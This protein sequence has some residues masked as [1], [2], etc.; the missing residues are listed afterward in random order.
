MRIDWYEQDKCRIQITNAIIQLRELLQLLKLRWEL[1]ILL[2]NG[3]CDASTD[4]CETPEARRS[5]GQQRIHRC[6][7]WTN[8]R[9]W[10][11]LGTRCRIE[12][13]I[14]VMDI[15]GYLDAEESL[16]SQTEV[17]SSERSSAIV[18]RKVMPRS[19]FSSNS[20]LRR[21]WSRKSC[22]WNVIFRSSSYEK[23]KKKK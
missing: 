6:G 22:R 15:W 1:G 19:R 7:K 2:N 9:V 20:R 8:A 5:A 14:K 10:Q 4:K 16:K 3:Q 12:S 11:G 21:F 18:A 23:R 17:R 13:V